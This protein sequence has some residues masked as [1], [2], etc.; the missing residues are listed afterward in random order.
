MNHE[1]ALPTEVKVAL[2][3]RDNS[4][5]CT[6]ITRC[7]SRAPYQNLNASTNILTDIYHGLEKLKKNK[8]FFI[9]FLQS[10]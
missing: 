5:S 6:M 8:Y 10:R 9:T 2:Q 4:Q 3:K 7:I 1:E